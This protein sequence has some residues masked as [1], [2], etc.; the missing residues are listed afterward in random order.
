MLVSQISRNWAGHPLRS[1][2][3]MLGLIRGTTTTNGLTVEPVLDPTAY[4]KGFAGAWK[5]SG[6]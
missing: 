6:D 5:R 3:I 2:P 4:V 1:L